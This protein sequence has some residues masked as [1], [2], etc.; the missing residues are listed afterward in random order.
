LTASELN[1]AGFYLTRSLTETGVY[2]IIS[3]FIDSRG[4]VHVGADYTFT[5]TSV[6]NGTTYFY[7]LLEIELNME[8][9]YYGPVHA[10]PGFLKILKPE[11]LDV[12]LPV[13][14]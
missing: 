12:N 10:T 1:T 7:K 5:D 14:R 2:T 6:V 9:Y 11:L 3:P 13:R 8:E 4:G